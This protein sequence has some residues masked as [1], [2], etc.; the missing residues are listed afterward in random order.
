MTEKLPEIPQS[1]LVFGLLIALVIMRCFGID[2][3][4]TAG[5]SL[6]IGFITGKQMERASSKKK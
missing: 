1:Y 2:S 4:T 5:L 3:F 6:V